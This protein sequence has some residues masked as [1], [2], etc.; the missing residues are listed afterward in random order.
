M[1]SPLH[2][3]GYRDLVG[4]A[5]AEDIGAR[6]AGDVL[7]TLHGPAAGVLGAERTL[8]NFLQHLCGIA[9]LTRA[10]VDHHIRVAGSIGEAVA[11]MTR[12]LAA[13]GAQRPIAVET[14]SL[15]QV[16]DALAAGADISLEIEIT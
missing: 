13:A 4:R 8:L 16:R 11:R 14:Q 2:P 7:A 6:E 10:C 9:T 5:L 1:S 3:D 15:D 12:A